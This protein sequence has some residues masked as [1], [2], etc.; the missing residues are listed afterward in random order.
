MAAILRSKHPDVTIPENLSCT[1]FIFQD[2]DKYGDKTAIV[3]CT[4]FLSLSYDTVFTIQCVTLFQ[5]SRESGRLIRL[6][7]LVILQ[8]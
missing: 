5:I 8:S 7:T 1:E 2:F 6:W 3:R 4:S